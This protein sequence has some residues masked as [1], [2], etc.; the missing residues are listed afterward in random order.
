M[1]TLIERAFGSP[2]LALV[3]KARKVRPKV[4]YYTLNILVKVYSFKMPVAS[5][6]I[7]PILVCRP[8]RW[9]RRDSTSTRQSSDW[10]INLMLQMFLLSRADKTAGIAYD[11][12]MMLM[13]IAPLC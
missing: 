4:F 8:T 10:A 6:R 2:F 1:Y 5:V 7:S 12:L 3:G 11:A 9:S 13:V